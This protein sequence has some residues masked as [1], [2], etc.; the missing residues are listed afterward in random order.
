VPEENAFLWE[1]LYEAL[2]FH[3]DDDAGVGEIVPAAANLLRNPSAEASLFA[4]NLSKAS[5]AAGEMLREPAAGP[6]GVGDWAIHLTGTKDAT[7]TGRTLS[8]AQ[9]SSAG[10]VEPGEAYSVGIPVWVVDA[11]ANGLTCRLD[12]YTAAPAYIGSTPTSAAFTGLGAG[13]ITLEGQVA[14]PTAALATVVL[15]GTTAA[16]GDTV[17]FWTDAWQFNQG[18]QAADYIDGDQP[19]CSWNG[20]PHASTSTRAAIDTTFPLR[21]WCEGECAPMQACYD[22]LRE[23]EDGTASWEILF[24]V[25]RCPAF[26]LPF[27]AQWVGVIVTPEMTEEQIRNEIRE[28]TAWKRGQPEAIRIGLRRTLV[29]EEPLVIVRSRTPEAGH[30]YIRTLKSQTPDPE[31]TERELRRNLLPA[32]EQLGYEAIEGVTVLDVAS[33]AKWATVADLAAAWP[34]VKALAEILPTDL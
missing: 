18:E 29:G 3:R 11:I 23:R 7:A 31:R 12:W 30:H 17:D 16:S 22:L 24:D 28:P 5:W 9:S 34:S 25:D 20:T 33:S 14:P 19:G 1:L 15:A 13:F 4:F 26:A 21:K 27:L 10:T 2:G 8:V 32:W 6:V